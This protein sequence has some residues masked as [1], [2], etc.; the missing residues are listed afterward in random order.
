[1]RRMSNNDLTSEAIA[2]L[3]RCLHISARRL[4]KM[5]ESSHHHD[6]QNDPF[7]RGAYSYVHVGALRARQVLAKSIDQTLFFAGE[8]THF[9]GQTGTVAGA[10]ATGHRAAEEILQA[11]SR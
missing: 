11:S 8:A 5:L 1:M 2:T 10:I 6:W 7:S 9:E 3:S 4:R